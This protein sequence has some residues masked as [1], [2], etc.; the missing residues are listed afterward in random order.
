[1]ELSTEAMIGIAFVAAMLLWAG[2][3][4][5]WTYGSHD[6]LRYW[7]QDANAR[8]DKRRAKRLRRKERE[9]AEHSPA[10]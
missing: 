9:R 3:M 4:A 2:F 6:V 10:S 8:A 5:G 1:M 7:R